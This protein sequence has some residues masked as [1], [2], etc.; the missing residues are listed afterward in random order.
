MR[1][2]KNKVAISSAHAGA[3]TLMFPIVA[4]RFL[5]FAKWYYCIFYIRQLITFPLSHSLLLNELFW[6]LIV[7][8]YFQSHSCTYFVTRATYIF[9][10]I[11]SWY[12]LLKR[13]S[14][15]NLS[16]AFCAFRVIRIN[17][18]IKAD[19]YSN[20]YTCLVTS[21]NLWITPKGF[22]HKTTTK[23]F[24]TCTVAPHSPYSRMVKTDYSRRT[25]VELL[26]LVLFL[27]LSR[28]LLKTE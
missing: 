13:I 18:S 23:Y 19:S 6:G 20:L 12:I 5:K 17:S 14:C 3:T 24:S 1:N 7:P 27:Q 15:C 2:N 10:V 26:S 16:K 21:H 4:P 22:L 8:F 25:I 9:P 28:A 11:P